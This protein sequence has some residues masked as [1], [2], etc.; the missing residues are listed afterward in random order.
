MFRSPVGSPAGSPVGSPVDHVAWI[1]EMDWKMLEDRF[2]EQGLSAM[3]LVKN[4]HPVGTILAIHFHLLAEKVHGQWMIK[5][6]IGP[7]NITGAAGHRNNSTSNNIHIPQGKYAFFMDITDE[8]RNDGPGQG[9]QYRY[10]TVD[11]SKMMECFVNDPPTESI[12]STTIT[13]FRFLSI[14]NTGVFRDVCMSQEEAAIP[15]H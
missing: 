14:S 6:E 4:N 13:Q 7:A 11:L 10:V 3:Y 2:M 5:M 1:P 8:V 9:R 15:T 12:N